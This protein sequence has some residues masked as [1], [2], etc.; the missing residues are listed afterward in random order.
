MQ[1]SKIRIIG[2]AWRSRLI[3]VL[4]V[5]D[6][7]PTPN[8]VRETLFNWLSF[9]LKDCFVLDAFC[10][11]GALGL[12][13]LSRGAKF[14]IGL[15]ISRDVVINFKNNLQKFGVQNSLAIEVNALDYLS[16]KSL[17]KFDVVFLDPPFNL[18]VIS[19]CCD[20]LARN[21][22]LNPNALIYVESKRSLSSL[23]FPANW[24]IFREKKAA[25]VYYG[26]LHFCT[27]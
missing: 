17:Q 18:D 22:W 6:L 24:H 3:E 1:N 8:R 20:L 14:V 13:A 21:D 19:D 11:S 12:E 23:K 26:L 5:K 25:N 27:G 15:D 9:K 16:A 4:D 2:G 7:R 10:G